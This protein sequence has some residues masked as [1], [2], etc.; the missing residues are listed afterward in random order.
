MPALG[1]VIWLAILVG[2][3]TLL[4]WLLSPD[5]RDDRGPGW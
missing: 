5:G 4:W 1:V 3:I 2:V